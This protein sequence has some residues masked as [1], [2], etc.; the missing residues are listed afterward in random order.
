MSLPRPPQPPLMGA[1][2]ADAADAADAADTTDTSGVP[3]VAPAK[4]AAAADSPRDTLPETEVHP[5]AADLN[6]D[7]HQLEHQL[8]QQLARFIIDGPQLKPALLDHF[9]KQ[10][11]AKAAAELAQ[12]TS[13]SLRLKGHG[14][15]AERSADPSDYLKT[16]ASMFN[17]SVATR[18]LDR[19]SADAESATAKSSAPSY[20]QAAVD[21]VQKRL[22]SGATQVDVSNLLSMTALPFAHKGAVERPKAKLLWRVQS[23]LGTWKNNLPEAYR[24]YYQMR[25]RRDLPAADARALS[26]E[27]LDDLAFT[28][29]ASDAAQGRLALPLQDHLSGD[30]SPPH[31]GSVT[32]WSD[33]DASPDPQAPD[34]AT[35]DWYAA[36]FVKLGF[37]PKDLSLRSPT[38][39]DALAHPEPEGDGRR[40]ISTAAV[41]FHK[42]ARVGFSLK[43]PADAQNPSDAFDNT[44]S[45]ASSG[46]AKSPTPAK[47][48]ARSPR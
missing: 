26:P 8:D 18:S 3:E 5:D 1:D 41:S 2:V 15:L 20:R 11:A 27:A 4:D 44:L 7:P 40:W 25:V 43:A 13:A 48:R 30:L 29:F 45:G 16:L 31:P 35:H 46:A 12:R 23:L 22:A 38:I 36:G 34:D 28:R 17:D 14:L 19:L 47:R 37:K 42:A 6:R 9:R 33:S 24:V 32:W 21:A 10:P 39:Y